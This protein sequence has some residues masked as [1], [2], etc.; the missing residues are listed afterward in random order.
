M[1]R[2]GMPDRQ[3]RMVAAPITLLM[4]GAGPPPTTIASLFGSAMMRLTKLCPP[5]RP[6][7][8]Q[9]RAAPAEKWGFRWLAAGALLVH[10]AC[11]ALGFLEISHE[12]YLLVRD[13]GAVRGRLRQREQRRREKRRRRGQPPSAIRLPVRAIRG[14]PFGGSAGARGG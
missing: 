6:A 14:A 9:T 12:D 11:E 4:P 7:K 13:D 10:S 1:P 3:A 8:A 2:T 5:A